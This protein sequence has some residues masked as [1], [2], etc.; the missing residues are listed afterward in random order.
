M[1]STITVRTRDSHGR[2]RSRKVSRNW[3]QW[4][5]RKSWARI[6]RTEFYLYGGFSNPDHV[7]KGTPSG[8]SYWRILR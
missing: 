8:W 2:L 1:T 4:F 6:T 7:R 3:V 5:A